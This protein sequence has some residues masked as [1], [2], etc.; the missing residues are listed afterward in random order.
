MRV[1]TYEVE[2]FDGNDEFFRVV[3]ER[4]G[5]DFGVELET[6]DLLGVVD[7]EASELECL[8]LALELESELFVVH[9]QEVKTALGHLHTLDIRI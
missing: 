8:L 2:E 4:E 6:Q 7:D 9:E 3:V 1:V 5:L